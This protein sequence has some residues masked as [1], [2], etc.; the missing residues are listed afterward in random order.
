MFSDCESWNRGDELEAATETVLWRL[1][2]TPLTDGDVQRAVFDEATLFAPR[3][4]GTAGE[5]PRATAEAS[6]TPEWSRVPE[7]VRAFCAVQADAVLE[8]ASA[9]GWVK[10]GADGAWHLTEAGREFLVNGGF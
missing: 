10:R 5:R 7:P 3:C 6:W 8:D 4:A 2:V 9:R 1:L